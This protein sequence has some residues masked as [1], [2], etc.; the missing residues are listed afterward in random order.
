M[1]AG[2]PCARK[3]PAASPNG[4]VIAGDWDRGPLIGGDSD[5]GRIRREWGIEALRPGGRWRNVGTMTTGGGEGIRAG[6]DAD[7]VAGMRIT[8]RECVDSS[9]CLR[10]DIAS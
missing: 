4:P 9:T 7:H 2:E 10:E 6:G 8:W 1:G 3:L 5:R